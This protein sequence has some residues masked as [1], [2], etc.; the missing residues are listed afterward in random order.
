[1]QIRP[2]LRDG[3]WW[4]RAGGGSNG[5]FS[6][7]TEAIE[8]T[9]AGLQHANLLQAQDHLIKEVL[10]RMRPGDRCPCCGE[11]TDG[12]EVTGTL[13][14][15]A[16]CPVCTTAD[17]VTSMMCRIVLVAHSREEIARQEGDAAAVSAWNEV[18]NIMSRLS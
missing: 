16:H 13:K 17:I 12:V 5:P 10:P 18:G 14:P 2:Y 3:A 4:T 8:E 9:I 1:M 15:Q 7:P 11:P 6:S